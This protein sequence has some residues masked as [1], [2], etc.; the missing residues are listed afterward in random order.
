[1]KR[2]VM[3]GDE[4]SPLGAIKSKLKIKEALIEFLVIC[5]IAYALIKYYRPHL[6]LNILENNI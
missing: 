3:A 5:S 4:W 6:R 2:N 1:M